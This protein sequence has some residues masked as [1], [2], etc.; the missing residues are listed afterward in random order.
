M[1]ALDYHWFSDVIAGWL[2]G[3][4]ILGVVLAVGPIVGSAARASLSR[5]AP[6]R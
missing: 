5:A 6:R 3:A 2:L 4:L 1:I